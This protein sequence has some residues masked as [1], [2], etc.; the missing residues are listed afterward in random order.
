VLRRYAGFDKHFVGDIGPEGGVLTEAQTADLFVWFCG[1]QIS[2]FTFTKAKRITKADFKSE[3]QKGPVPTLN[4]WWGALNISVGYGI[5]HGSTRPQY[6]RPLEKKLTHLT[7]ETGKHLTGSDLPEHRVRL[8][9]SPMKQWNEIL[10]EFA[11][12]VEDKC[13]GRVMF[14]G[15]YAYLESQKDA[16]NLMLHDSDPT[17][18]G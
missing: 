3:R 13:E 10:P 5:Q 9:A 6:R 17:K 2:G 12:W 14:A 18:V 16:A 1:T 11:A 15:G 4:G 8:A 7:K